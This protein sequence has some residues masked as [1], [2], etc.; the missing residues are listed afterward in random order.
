MLVLLCVVLCAY[1]LLCG[2]QQAPEDLRPDVL[3]YQR[4]EFLTQS[5]KNELQRDLQ[6]NDAGVLPPDVVLPQITAAE[7]GRV[8]TLTLD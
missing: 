5:I 4:L 6:I 1:D 3:A 7:Y 2:T 8:L